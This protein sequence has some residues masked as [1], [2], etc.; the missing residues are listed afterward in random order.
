V[1]YPDGV[2]AEDGLIWIV[3][4]RDRQGAG[5]ILLATFRE[6]DVVAGKDVSGRAHLRHVVNKLKLDTYAARTRASAGHAPD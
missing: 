3:Y 5:E 6:E 1:S 2:Q 4:D